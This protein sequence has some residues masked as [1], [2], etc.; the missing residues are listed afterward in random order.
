MK[1]EVID[2]SAKNWQ[3]AIGLTAHALFEKGY[4]KTSFKEGCIDREK[5][6]PTGLNTPIPIAIP[7]TE[8]EHVNCSAVCIL[9]LKQPCVF[10]N[11]EDP[12]QSVSVQYVLNLAIHDK[13]EHIQVLS[14]I[15]RMFQND[16]FLKKISS[17]NIDDLKTA[18]VEYISSEH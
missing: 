5:Q 3:E 7:H 1:I 11:M 13:R 16:E 8:S 17:I 14:K 10:M 4:V 15:I 2:G 18:I 9:R 12:N 6:F